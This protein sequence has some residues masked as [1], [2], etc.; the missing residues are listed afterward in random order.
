MILTDEIIEKA[1]RAASASVGEKPYKFDKF[2]KE[3]PS[4]YQEMA[5]VIRATLESVLPEILEECA[6]VCDGEPVGT[7]FR[8]WSYMEGNQSNDSAMTRHSDMLALAIR[9]LKPKEEG[10]G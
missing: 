4:E 6:K 3:N 10:N 2:K 7:K 8:T 5:G 9:N 1:M